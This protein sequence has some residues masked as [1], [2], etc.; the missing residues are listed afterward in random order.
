MPCVPSVDGSRQTVFLP[1]ALRDVREHLAQ[2]VD[3]R[4]L[5][6]RLHLGRALRRDRPAE[7]LGAPVAAARPPL[8]VVDADVRRHHPG[9]LVP[10]DGVDAA[11]EHPV[12]PLLAERAVGGA[13]QA[14]TG[15]AP[16]VVEHLALLRDGT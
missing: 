12:G 15:D 16:P 2:E 10:E 7:A 5:A 1:A 3:D 14:R 8:G 13:V 4:R 6:E 11:L 9:R